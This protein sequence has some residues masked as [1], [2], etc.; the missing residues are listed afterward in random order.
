[1]E[2]SS[3]TAASSAPF[4]SP[5]SYRQARRTDVT[6]LSIC[7]ASRCAHVSS[8]VSL[9]R[10]HVS[11]QVCSD[12]LCIFECSDWVSKHMKFSLYETWRGEVTHYGDEMVCGESGTGYRAGIYPSNMLPSILT[13]MFCPT[14]IPKR[15]IRPI[16][17]LVWLWMDIHQY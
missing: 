17:G 13:P 1:M 6:T 4:R 10:N 9:Q 14:S 5:H 7:S 16:Y 2:N 8:I 15:F 3:I 11:L 12:I